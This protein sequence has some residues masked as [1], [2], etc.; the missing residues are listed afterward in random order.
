[1]EAVNPR[2]DMHAKGSDPLT[3]AL[4]APE[5]R[6]LVSSGPKKMLEHQF[7]QL[8]LGASSSGEEAEGD[9]CATWVTSSSSQ[10]QA[11]CASAASSDNRSS[12]WQQSG[13]DRDEPILQDNH[14]RFCLLPVK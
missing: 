9:E 5:P 3:P 8:D 14:D 12:R 11:E 7:D 13:T 4:R 6:I 10:L 1:M 2:T